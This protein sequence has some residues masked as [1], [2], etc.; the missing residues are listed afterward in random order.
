[1]VNKEIMMRTSLYRLG[2]ADDKRYKGINIPF[3][4]KLYNE[5]LKKYGV[6]NNV[7]N[8][9]IIT[10]S[11]S[12]TIRGLLKY[13][14]SIGYKISDYKSVSDHKYKDIVLDELREDYYKLEYNDLREK[15]GYKLYSG[16]NK[17]RKKDPT[18]GK[19]KC[20]Q[21]YLQGGYR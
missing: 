13:A 17:L 4:V 10:H 19:Y 5:N 16:I 1:M 3:V 9:A 12:T 18:F 21:L 15:Y 7:N 8:I 6:I 2:L 14:K 20:R 11:S